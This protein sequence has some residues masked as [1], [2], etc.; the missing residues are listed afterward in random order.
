MGKRKGLSLP[1]IIIISFILSSSVLASFLLWNFVSSRWA[2]STENADRLLKRRK[3]E[4][5]MAIIN[6]KDNVDRNIPLLIEKGRIWMTLAWE[7]Q[8]RKG[9]SDYGLDE[10]EWMKSKESD[11]SVACFKRVLELDKNN[12]D[13]RYY[14]GVICMDKGWHSEAQD[15]FMEILDNNVKDWETRNVMGVLYTRMKQYPQALREFQAAWKQ[16]GEDISIAK[17]MGSLYRRYLNKPDSAMIWMNRYLNLNPQSDPDAGRI[18]VDLTDMIKRYP[19]YKLQ[20]PMNWYGKREF[21]A[22]GDEAFQ[23]KK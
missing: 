14:L 10:K 4:K 9:W 2:P 1:V 11:S 20:E 7:M 17:N 21:D 15:H 19:E 3:Y 12:R 6:Q 8:N 18:R 5:A 13:A 16:N 23:F 22:R